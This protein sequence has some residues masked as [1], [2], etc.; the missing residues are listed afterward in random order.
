MSDPEEYLN[1]FQ[2]VCS[3]DK[4]K[5]VCYIDNDTI[6][7]APEYDNY[8]LVSKFEDDGKYYFCYDMKKHYFE[9][10]DE[11][12]RIKYEE[13]K[14]YNYLANI[15]DRANQFK[16][17]REEFEQRKIQNIAI[18]NRNRKRQILN[19]YKKIKLYQSF[20]LTYK[21]FITLRISSLS[22]NDTTN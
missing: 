5:C 15:R 7:E 1:K 13:M 12:N 22:T 6:P 8:E 4:Y 14:K 9:Y 2:V 20:I 19:K 21:L 10:L 3:I 17:S 18:F 11:Q 16:K